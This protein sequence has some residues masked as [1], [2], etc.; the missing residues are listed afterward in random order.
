MRTGPQAD[1]ANSAASRP[2]WLPSSRERARGIVV[3][4]TKRQLGS[5]PLGALDHRAVRTRADRLAANPAHGLNLPKIST[6][7]K[8]YFS[9]QQVGYSPMSSMIFTADPFRPAERSWAA[10]AGIRELRHTAAS[11]ATSAGANVKAVQRMLGHASPAV[12]LDVYSDL[13]DSD[14]DAVSIDFD[15]AIV[16]STDANALSL[17]GVAK[18]GEK[19]S[20]LR[21]AFS[22]GAPR[23]IRTAA[24][25]SGG[26][27][28]IP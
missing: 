2:D 5:Y 11:L 9:H 1:P 16:E 12:T 10:R 15:H 3:R 26:Q 13:F 17:D 19:Q 22:C 4:H 23:Q 8:R 20:G 21:P 24:P 27:C 18:R 7:S 6:A 28:S 14:L 25:A